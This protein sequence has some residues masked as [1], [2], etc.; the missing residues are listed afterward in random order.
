MGQLGPI[1][2]NDSRDSVVIRLMNMM[3][4]AKQRGAEVII[5]PELALTTFF[6]RWYYPTMKEVDQWFETEMPNT[7]T[8]PL[9]D[10]AKELKIGFY[11]GYAEMVRSGSD[12]ENKY[13]NTSILVNQ[14]AEIIG[15]YHKVH[16][17]GHNEYEPWREFQHLERR[18][19]TPGT[20]FP[21]FEAFGTTIGMAICNDRRWAETYRVMALRGA[22]IIFIGY[23]TPVHNAPA[24]M[25]DDLSLFQNALSLQAG[26]YQNGIWVVGVAKA[27]NEEN[28]QMI[29][30]SSIVAPSGEIYA[31]CITKG[32]EVV[33]ATC[34][35][36]F[37]D[38]Y[39]KT[40]FNFKKFRVP[41]AYLP[42]VEE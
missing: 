2:R 17:P 4:I 5:Y 14:E 28:I 42:I 10:L 37:C 23:N 32:D 6:P 11:L 8:Q 34:D 13:F 22:K 24:P 19:F 9:F 33:V 7:A 30:G 26:A 20:D 35:L 27:G 21:V 25:H 1:N 38:V 29:G 18:Y 3:K 15:K 12:R 40:T 16:V 39:Q 41:Q 36:D 31:R